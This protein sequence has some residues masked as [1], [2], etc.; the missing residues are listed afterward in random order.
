MDLVPFLERDSGSIAMFFG[1]PGGRV[2]LKEIEKLFQHILRC[3]RF[4]LREMAQPQTSAWEFLSSLS[5]ERRAV[6][7]ELVKR[8]LRRIPEGNVALWQSRRAGHVCFEIFVEERLIGSEKSD[9]SN[10][11]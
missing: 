7:D 3:H 11:K 9:H 10:N 2:V 6:G 8:S 5:R 4:G 1:E